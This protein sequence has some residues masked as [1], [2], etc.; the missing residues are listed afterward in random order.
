MSNDILKNFL[1]RPRDN[2]SSSEQ[3]LLSGLRKALSSWHD[4]NMDEVIWAWGD[5][6]K[7]LLQWLSK[8]N[9]LT[10]SEKELV[11]GYYD[12]L[13]KDQEVGM[14]QLEIDEGDVN[15]EDQTDLDEAYKEIFEPKPSPNREEAIENFLVEGEM[16]ENASTGI[17]LIVQLERLGLKEPMSPEDAERIRKLFQEMRSDFGPKLN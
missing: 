1:E 8:K 2:L 12:A 16:L 14:D 7:V 13:Q 5:A 15:I 3:E 4:R 6:E 10:D 9:A 17:R 11:N